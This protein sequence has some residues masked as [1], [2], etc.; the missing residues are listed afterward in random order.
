VVNEIIRPEFWTAPAWNVGD[1][2]RDM[3]MA[4]NLRMPLKGVDTLLEAMAIVRQAIPGVRLKVAAGI[5]KRSG[6][7]RHVVRKIARLG[8]TD[9]IDLMGYLGASDLVV[10]LRSSHCFVA[11]SVIDNSPNSV[12]EAMLVGLPVV[13]SY[14]GGIPSLIRHEHSGL[15]APPCE[16]ALLAHR[17]FRILTDDALAAALGQQARQA[18][19]QR[20]DATKIVASLLFAY[21]DVLARSGR[22]RS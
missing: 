9:S 11:P 14:A 12:C 13:A 17:V 7:G 19:R 16:P 2:R 5:A 20:H 10:H 21:Q 22:G 8:L 6:Y 1:C 3:L 4:T 15:L 18:A